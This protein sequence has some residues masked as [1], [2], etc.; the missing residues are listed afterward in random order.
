MCTARFGCYGRRM[1]VKGPEL[2]T[3]LDVGFAVVGVG[4]TATALWVPGSLVRTD[5]TGPPLLLAVLP[6]LIGGS[7][8]LRRRAPLLM[9]VMLWAGLSVQAL[10]THQ[11]PR[12]PELTFVVSAASYALAAHDTL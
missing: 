11:P 12:G 10:S 5:V 6:L 1:Q 9:W 3:V 4:L 8:L 7:L 2:G